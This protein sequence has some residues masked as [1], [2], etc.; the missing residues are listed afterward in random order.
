M[1]AALFREL[2]ELAHK[3]DDLCILA[4]LS[5][6]PD[7]KQ[8]AHDFS[9]RFI[10]ISAN[11][12]S[13]LSICEAL[14]QTNKSV[15]L[16]VEIPSFIVRWF[17]HLLLLLPKLPGRLVIIGIPNQQSHTN[18]LYH[19][20]RPETVLMQLIP[21][22]TVIAPST[23]EELGV[24]LT[25]AHTL[26]QVSYIHFNN[27]QKSLVTEPSAITPQLFEPIKYS[28]GSQVICIG[29]GSGLSRAYQAKLHLEEYGYSTALV[30]MPTIQPLNEPI[31]RKYL[32]S[33][34]AFFVF[35]G[36]VPTLGVGSKI[37]NFIAENHERKIIFKSFH[38]S[39]GSNNLDFRAITLEILELMAQFNIIP[40][41]QAWQRK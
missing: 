40:N 24:L 2:Y 9:S 35:E 22:V 6:H 34:S 19:H 12:H 31:L 11:E 23:H 4:S 39:F 1:K 33:Y 27:L 30:S 13:A 37:G 5:Q 15:I 25:H 38:S 41:N 10:D 7:F 28:S 20:A 17:E 16:C 21:R 29:I 18:S 32:H 14:I 3:D 36:D 8:I 26:K